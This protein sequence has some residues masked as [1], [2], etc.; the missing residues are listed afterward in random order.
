MLKLAVFS[1]KEQAVALL[2]YMHFP[3]LRIF[4]YR[5]FLKRPSH[6]E[7]FFTHHRELSALLVVLLADPPTEKCWQHRYRMKGNQLHQE[8][9]V[10]QWSTKQKLCCEVGQSCCRLRRWPQ[11]QS[12]PPL[13]AQTD[14]LNCRVPIINKS[15]QN[16]DKWALTE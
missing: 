4:H 15:H 6:L 13:G 1:D 3:G 7:W 14:R 12:L 9:Q 5:G 16:M 10:S 8:H 2:L 11:S